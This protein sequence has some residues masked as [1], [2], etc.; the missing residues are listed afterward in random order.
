[1]TGGVGGA[2]KLVNKTK[3]LSSWGFYSSSE[4]NNTQAVETMSRTVVRSAMNGLDLHNGRKVASLAWVAGTGLSEE[5]IH[6]WPGEGEDPEEEN[7]GLENNRL[8]GHKVGLEG[9]HQC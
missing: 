4:R 8:K 5:V 3:P 7:S 6:R 2:G 1:M 9:P